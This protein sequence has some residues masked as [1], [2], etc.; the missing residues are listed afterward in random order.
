MKIGTATDFSARKNWSLSLFSRP[1]F[2][3]GGR[4][5]AT[6]WMRAYSV[7]QQIAGEKCGLGAGFYI[8]LL[9]PG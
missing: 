1:Y 8:D 4:P 3:R 2:P 6:K 5:S 7:L 9:F